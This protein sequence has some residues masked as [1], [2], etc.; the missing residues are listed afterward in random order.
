MA[1]ANYSKAQEVCVSSAEA[2]G[3]MNDPALV[4]VM[5]IPDADEDNVAVT[6]W[7]KNNGQL[8]PWI[9]VQQAA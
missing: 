9:I 1:T 2:I 4:V 3:M 8:P 5:A 6:Y 7:S